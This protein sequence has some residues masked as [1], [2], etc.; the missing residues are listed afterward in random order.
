VYTQQPELG[1]LGGE[2]AATKSIPTCVYTAAQPTGIIE[3]PF[4]TQKFEP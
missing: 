1:D 2:R 3:F 4:L